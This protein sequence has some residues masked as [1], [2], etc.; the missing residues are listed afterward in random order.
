MIGRFSFEFYRPIIY[1][2][3]VFKYQSFSGHLNKSPSTAS[4]FDSRQ[5]INAL[6]DALN[7]ARQRQML[8]LMV[9]FAYTGFVVSLYNLVLPTAVGS[10]QSLPNAK[11]MVGL[12]GLLVGTGKKS[13][14]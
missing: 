10:T 8:L 2:C 13:I 3:T 5:A 4:R 14:F 9:T 6:K 1:R 11:S 12:V 7:A